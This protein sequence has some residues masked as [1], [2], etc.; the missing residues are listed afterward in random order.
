MRNYNAK[1]IMGM[2][3]CNPANPRG[4]ENIIICDSAVLYNKLKTSTNDPSISKAM[5]RSQIMRT[6]PGVK[7]AQ[8]VTISTTGETTNSSVP[9]S[10]FLKISAFITNVTETGLTLNITGT[11]CTVNVSYS[12]NGKTINLENINSNTIVISNLSNKDIDNKTNY[13]YKFTITPF[14][15]GYRGKPVIIVGNTIKIN[16]IATNITSNG[17]TINVTGQFHTLDVKYDDNKETISKLN[18]ESN[19][20]IISNLTNKPSNEYKFII[21]PYAFGYSGQPFVLLVQTISS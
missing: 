14:G 17:C 10:T 3:H 12:D 11:F 1:F 13:I 2:K 4:S 20:I 21:I 5:R 9:F 18:I 19:T 8:T 15:F 16:A 6:S 7:T